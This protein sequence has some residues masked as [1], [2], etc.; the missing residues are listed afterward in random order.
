MRLHRFFLLFPSGAVLALALGLAF[1]WF[2]ALANED[3][4][5]QSLRTQGDGR[6][7]LLQ[8]AKTHGYDRARMAAELIALGMTCGRSPGD[9]EQA[10]YRFLLNTCFGGVF[11][12]NKTFQYSFRA[13]WPGY[14]V[15]DDLLFSAGI[16]FYPVFP[17]GFCNPPE[18]RLQRQ[19][20]HLESIGYIEVRL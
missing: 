19:I 16:A 8:I 14:E 3:D 5:F 18:E 4:I 17:F 10:S 13:P 6:N 7:H 1:P 2:N 9:V 15:F 12:G 11:E 20:N